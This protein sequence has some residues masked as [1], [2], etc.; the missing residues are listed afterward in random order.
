MRPLSS[1]APV[2]VLRS[3]VRLPRDF[4]TT[5]CF[6]SFQSS[7]ASIWGGKTAGSHRRSPASLNV[8]NKPLKVY[9]GLKS[10]RESLHERL[11]HPALTGGLRKG[12]TAPL[13]AI[14]RLFNVL[15]ERP[16]SN[17]RLTTLTKVL[18]RKRP[19]LLPLFDTKIEHCY[20]L[21]ANAPVKTGKATA[22]FPVPFRELVSKPPTS[23]RPHRGG[24]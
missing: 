1:V 15:E 6:R 24:D 19:D 17:V 11:K 23:L 22:N 7:E 3:S 8:S 12:T 20:T 5:S 18:H 9:Y 10:Q 2:G 14:A 16:A 21:C 4:N 13:D